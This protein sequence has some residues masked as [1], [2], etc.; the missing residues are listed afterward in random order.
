MLNNQTVTGNQGM[1]DVGDEK[2]L[3]GRMVFRCNGAQASVGCSKSAR[4]S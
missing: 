3:G 1:R 2:P 4:L